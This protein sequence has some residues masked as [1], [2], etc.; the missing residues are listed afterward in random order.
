MR[1]LCLNW[2][3]CILLAACGVDLADPSGGLGPGDEASQA[4]CRGR[5]F[6]V[7]PTGDDR[8]PGTSLARAWRTIERANRQVFLAGDELRF[9][10]GFVYTGNLRFDARDAGIQAAPIRIGSFGRGRATIEAGTG[11][12]LELS[13]TSGFEVEDLNLHGDWDPLAQD[14]NSGEGLVAINRMGGGR[15]LQ[16]LR[17]RR[18]DVSGFKTTGIALR[19][20]PSDDSK[21]GGY[22]DVEITDCSVHDNAD[23]GVIS[24]GPFSDVAGYSHRALVVK[25]L[26]VFSNRGLKNKGAHTGSG[27]M[28]ADVDGALIEDSV[29]HDNGEFND[30]SGGGGFG[31]W[32]WDST[33]VVIRNNESYANKTGTADGGGFDLDGGVT[34]SVME[35]N[36]S[37]DNQG[38]GYGAFQFMYARPYSGNTIRYN[39]SQNDGNAVL[40]WDGNGDM[41]AL[42]VYQNVGYSEHIAVVSYSAVQAVRLL[43]NI[44]FGTGEALFDI[45]DDSGLI[46][47][48]NDYWTG[49]AP[50]KL[51]W[52]TGT[53]APLEFD[54]FE[55]FRTATRHEMQGSTVTGKNVDPQLE[56]AG[57]APTLNDATLL[58]TLT[59]YGLRPDS[60][61]VDQGVDLADFEIDAGD[62]DFFGRRS[63]RGAGFDV[64]A[65]EM[66]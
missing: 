18:L 55:T 57:E 6:Y 37:H 23:F 46:L 52:N 13:N 27:I 20:Q 61:L 64:G 40:L 39:I 50:F 53:S 54:S 59:E 21:G 10:A 66:R 32:A 41:G 29:A 49:D 22:D 3:C 17:F 4:R 1:L 28:L 58:S 65:A 25:R 56:A 47:Q 31:I 42:D 2:V 11:T 12:A 60:A 62:R 43:N 48:G 38:T 14:G 34:Q 33:H 35:Y 24:D 36:Y 15:R 5:S 44:F 19:A 63:P 7:R 45:Y 30:H 9:E 16:Y 26:R 8:N 51:R